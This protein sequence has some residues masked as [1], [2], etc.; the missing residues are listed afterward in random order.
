METEVEVGRNEASGQEGARPAKILKSAHPWGP[1]HTSH[2]GEPT[3]AS[4]GPQRMFLAIALDLNRSALLSL[5]LWDP[6]GHSLISHSLITAESET[7][8]TLALT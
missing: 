5:C 8:A 3:E 1:T 2:L 4:L 7:E 6:S